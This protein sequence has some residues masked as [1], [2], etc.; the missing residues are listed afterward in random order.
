MPKGS[1]KP[2]Y[3]IRLYTKKAGTYKFSFDAILKDGSTVKKTYRIIAKD[4]SEPIKCITYG[5]KI[6]SYS[7]DYRDDP[8]QGNAVWTR[9][10]G[11]G[12]TTKKSGIFKVTMSKYFKLLKIEVGTPIYKKSTDP[13]EGLS[14]DMSKVKTELDCISNYG[15]C[16]WKKVQN[17]KKI[18]LNMNNKTE[19]GERII[20]YIRITYYDK[21]NKYTDRSTYSIYLLKK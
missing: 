15:A 17:G 4:Y 5:G 14:Y 2:Y 12:T 1:A 21:K 19:K 6:L 20:T 8:I 10:F 13:N 16:R 7:D 9:H 11:H 18:K 3:R